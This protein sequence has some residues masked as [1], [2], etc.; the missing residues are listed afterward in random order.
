MNN[1]IA[2]TTVRSVSPIGEEFAGVIGVGA[3]VRQKTG[4]YGCAVVLPPDY[5]SKMI[6]GEDSLQCLS[7]ALRFTADR[8]NDYLAKGWKFLH[9]DSN[10]AIP[11]GAYFMHP[12]WISRLEAIGR[13]AEQVVAPNRSLAPSSES[14]SPARGSDDF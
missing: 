6:F 11:F 10:E 2:Q 3:P 1:L 5:D 9:P 8:I 13:Q 12:E 14:T 4:A 7:L